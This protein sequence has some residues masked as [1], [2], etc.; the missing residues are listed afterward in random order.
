M[1]PFPPPRTVSMP[2]SLGQAGIEELE[3]EPPSQ[4][5][6]LC[7]WKKY[8]ERHFAL[9]IRHPPQGSSAFSKM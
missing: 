7:M 1:Q 4:K 6:L 5:T 3:T 8:E 9:F 2:V